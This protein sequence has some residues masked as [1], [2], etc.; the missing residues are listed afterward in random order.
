MLGNVNKCNL[1]ELRF[2]NGEW[3]YTTITK[4]PLLR[5]PRQVTIPLTKE[6]DVPAYGEL[7]GHCVTPPV[8]DSDNILRPGKEDFEKKYTTYKCNFCNAD[9]Y[10]FNR[11]TPFA[12]VKSKSA[13]ASAHP[14][15]DQTSMQENRTGEPGKQPELENHKNPV[16]VVN[17]FK[18]AIFN[19][20]KRFKK[21]IYWLLGLGVLSYGAFQFRDSIPFRPAGDEE[22]E[23][24]STVQKV[25]GVGALLGTAVAGYTA[26]KH[27]SKS[28]PAPQKSRS[29]V[30]CDSLCSDTK[31]SFWSRLKLGLV[32]TRARTV[33]GLVMIFLVGLAILAFYRLRSGEQNGWD[34]DE[35]LE[36]GR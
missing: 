26:Y 35:D 18:N 29:A 16:N 23:G 8:L 6:S 15:R 14:T 36:W 24:Y 4:K 10:L 7:Y 31:M 27:F 5:K 3:D 25:A 2:G 32:I 33:F 17:E 1:T 13:V 22:E 9:R 21:A 20:V 19:V 12:T 11:E 30:T 34:G 28:T